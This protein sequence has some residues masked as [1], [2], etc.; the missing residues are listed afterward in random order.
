MIIS[1]VVNKE[2]ASRDLDNWLID[3]NKFFFKPAKEI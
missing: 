1:I 2:L 3:V